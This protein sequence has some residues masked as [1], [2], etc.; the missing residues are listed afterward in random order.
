[1]Q[2][3]WPNDPTQL[4]ATRRSAN[5]APTSPMAQH[6]PAA[7]AQASLPHQGTLGLVT[8]GAPLPLYSWAFSGP[9]VPWG[10]QPGFN[11]TRINITQDVPLANCT[12]TIKTVNVKV[13][14]N[15]VAQ[16]STKRM[17]EIAYDIH[18]Q[19]SSWGS[20]F[21]LRFRYELCTFD[22]FPP[23]SSL[24]ISMLFAVGVALTIS[25]TKRHICGYG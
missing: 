2:W 7:C 22:S 16:Y 19:E 21:R 8:Q 12:N 13:S 3:P 24:I 1:M 17:V 11:N 15:G 25:I 20:G 10:Y 4:T 9:Q 14:R 5:R 23:A 6:F 18:G